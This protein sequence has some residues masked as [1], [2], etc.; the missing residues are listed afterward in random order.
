MGIGGVL[1]ALIFSSRLLTYVAFMSISIALLASS[2]SRLRQLA[3]HFEY[4]F[5]WRSSHLGGADGWVFCGER[6]APRVFSLVITVLSVTG[7][8]WSMVSALA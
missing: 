6:G 5:C 7:V 3:S 4:F 1:R 8:P 2:F